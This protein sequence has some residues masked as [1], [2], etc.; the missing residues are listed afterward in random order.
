MRIQQNTKYKK[1]MTPYKT[2]NE[3]WKEKI[4]P[5]QRQRQEHQ[6]ALVL[7]TQQIRPQRYTIVQQHHK[8]THTY[9]NLRTQV[10]NAD[11]KICSKATRPKA[12]V[13]TTYKHHMHHKTKLS[14]ETGKN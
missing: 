5:G 9:N 3:R 13:T 11:S 1:E 8:R 10:P 6:R 7:C 12:E 14:S 2:R 4:T